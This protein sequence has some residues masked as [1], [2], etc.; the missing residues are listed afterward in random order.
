[1]TTEI[2]QLRV[3]LNEQPKSTQPPINE[4]DRLRIAELETANARLREEIARIKD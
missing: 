1:M 4:S 2:N 3:Q